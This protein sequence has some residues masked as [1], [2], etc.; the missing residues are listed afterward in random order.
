M[1]KIFSILFILCSI[2]SFS[3]DSSKTGT[4]TVFKY[5]NGKISS[6]GKIRNGKPDGYWKTFY[7]NGILK[8]E[9]NRK[10]YELDS[11]WKFYNEDGKLILDINYSKGK[12]NGIKTTYPQNEIIKENYVNDVKE[13]F[14]SYYYPDNKLRL[15]VKFVKGKEQGLAREYSPEGNVITLLEYKNGYLISKEK[16][17]RLNYD[18]LKQGKWVTF[19]SNGNLQS[20]GYY[21][22]GIKNGYFKEYSQDGNLVSVTKYVNGEIQKDASEIAK[23]DIKTEYYDNGQIKKVGSFK[24]NIP[25]G[26]SREYSQE[27]KILASKVYL[28]GLVIGDGIVDATGLK[29]GPW[30][31]YYESGEL[32]SAGKYVNGLKYGEWKFY[33]K[34]GKI[35]QTGTY[36]RN[37]KPDGEW[38]WYYEN[39][40]VLR[41]EVYSDGLEN[42][43]MIEYSDTGTVISKGEYVDGLEEGPW[44]YQLGDIKVEGSYKEGKRTGTWKYWYDNGNL[45]FEGSYLD[46]NADGKHIYYW[47]NGKV[48]EEGNYIMGKREGEWFKYNYD[49]TLFLTTLYKN[50]IEIKYDGV[51]IKPPTEDN[52]ND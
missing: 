7:E 37:E 10:N 15:S 11:I 42:G 3:Q 18:S 23:L 39:G 34:N 16:V 8:S 48:K 14:T 52:S 31:E 40:S 19:Y 33:Y 50:G 30:K 28:S 45:N 46:D 38:I 13:G 26:I 29:Q 51:K 24:N 22:A 25:E 20:E 47:D 17:N 12:K 43:A 1:K 49:G 41:N 36:L 44:T 6:E 9:G 2:V 35:E 5:E 27:G 21:S 32:K 4:F